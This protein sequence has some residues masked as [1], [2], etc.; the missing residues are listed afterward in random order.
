VA[1]PG[2]AAAD[3]P[4]YQLPV[5]LPAAKA[6]PPV[7]AKAP[8]TKVVLSLIHQ[9][10]P[11]NPPTRE[12]LAKASQLLHDGL[13]DSCHNVGPVSAPTGTDPSIAPICWTDAQGVLNTSG[14]NARGSTGPT[15]LMALGST[16]D[17]GLGNAWGQTEGT[18]SRAFMVTGMFGPQTDLDR[19]P[20]WGRNL[21]TT[22]EDPYLSHEM[23]AAQINGMQG[24]GAM[25]E[26][27]HFAV[28]NGQNQNINTDIGDQALHENYLLPYEGGFVTARPQRPC[29]R[30]SSGAT[31]RRTCRRTC[32][33]SRSRARSRP[34]R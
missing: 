18:E 11:D 3:V 10:E 4:P 28:Y 1:W 21:T 13:N 32:P 16:F 12:E 14:P 25:S 27:K 17:R 24:S 15:T 29:A 20:N 7:D 9:L 26:M 19:L 31:P 30:T 23:V 33:R 34:A 6:S 22:G 5:A 8:Y 2:A